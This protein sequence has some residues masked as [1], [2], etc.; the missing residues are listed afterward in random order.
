MKQAAR[1]RFEARYPSGKGE[2]CKTFMRRFDSDPRL[3][4]FCC[5]APSRHTGF[6]RSVLRAPVTISPTAR[7]FILPGKISFWKTGW[8]KRPM[9]RLVSRKGRK[10]RAERTK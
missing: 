3:H 7:I 2:V 9:E 5:F 10:G 8:N 4:Q 1:I 6:P